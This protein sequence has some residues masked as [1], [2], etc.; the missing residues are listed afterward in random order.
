MICQSVKNVKV[1]GV[2]YSIYFINDSSCDYLGQ[3]DTTKKTIILNEVSN[4]C[5]S[6]VIFHE[7]L[8]AYFYE[9]GLISYYQDERLIYWLTFM[10]DK[11]V[12]Q[13]NSIFS[14][15]EKLIEL[16]KDNKNLPNIEFI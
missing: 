8:H 9:C 4:D 5:M 11:M 2:L 7:L 10:I 15:I 1:M 13:S 3:T 12:T 14:D 16:N 6:E